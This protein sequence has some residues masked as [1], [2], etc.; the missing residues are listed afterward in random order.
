M[1]NETLT[2]LEQQI[3]SIEAPLTNNNPS[4]MAPEGRE[5][6]ELDLQTSG[7][8]LTDPEPF[9]DDTWRLTYP[10][11]SSDRPR[12]DK[13][14]IVVFKQKH[15]P[16]VVKVQ[17]PSTRRHNDHSYSVGLTS[18]SGIYGHDHFTRFFVTQKDLP[19]LVEPDGLT[20]ALTLL[21]NALAQVFPQKKT[22]HQKHRWKNQNLHPRFN[23]KHF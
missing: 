7:W 5:Q 14:Q 18:G 11:N 10:I 9:P 3:R 12:S 2:L 23:S 16:V 6:L 13:D 20:D 4:S 8:G 21:N 1:A 17:K 15:G 19:S 22:N